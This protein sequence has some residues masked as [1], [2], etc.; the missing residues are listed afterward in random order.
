MEVSVFFLLVSP[1]QPSSD[2]SFLPLAFL[3]V[4][5]LSSPFLSFFSLFSQSQCCHFTHPSPNRNDTK[6]S[7]TH[8]SWS[9]FALCRAL[10]AA[11]IMIC[12]VCTEFFPCSAVERRTA[13]LFLAFLVAQLRN[14]VF[15]HGNM[16]WG[17]LTLGGLRIPRSL[18]IPNVQY[19]N[20][21]PSPGCHYKIALSAF[22]YP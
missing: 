9:H 13:H 2:L 1:F 12:Y 8:S 11:R 17:N 19:G 15:A 20:N 7:I 16:W 10:L 4:S 21:L 6:N 14:C 18:S 3:N 22:H 5:V